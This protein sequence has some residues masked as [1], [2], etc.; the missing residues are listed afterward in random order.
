MNIAFR[1][2]LYQLQLVHSSLNQLLKRVSGL[3]RP[4]STDC[5][6]F[7]SS[8]LRKDFFTFHSCVKSIC[9]EIMCNS[10]V[11]WAILL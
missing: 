11:G 9:C 10:L 7:F 3:V 6:T 5:Q 4:Y 8:D 1:P 2:L